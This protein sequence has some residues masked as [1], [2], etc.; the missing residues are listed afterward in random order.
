ML[1]GQGWPKPLLLE[2]RN[3]PRPEQL[4]EATSELLSRAAANI[5]RDLPVHHPRLADL[6]RLTAALMEHTE[7]PLVADVL[8]PIVRAHPS[9]LVRCTI[10]RHVTHAGGPSALFEPIAAMLDGE[11]AFAL[12]NHLYMP[13]ANAAMLVDPDTTFDRLGHHLWSDDGT[14][15][16]ETSRLKTAHVIRALSNKGGAPI[17]G[18][19]WS[20]VT[21]LLVH[22]DF[23][24]SSSVVQL[25]GRHRSDDRARASVREVLEVVVVQ[26]DPPPWH[27][28]L[29]AVGDLGL[30]EAVP[31][32]ISA[33]E[34]KLDGD[35]I[36]QEMIVL[37]RLG[38]PL[39]LGDL[40]AAKA[41]SKHGQHQR[42]LEGLIAQLEPAA[43]P[44]KVDDQAKR[45]PLV[46]PTA[47]RLRLE[48]STLDAS[49]IEQLL[50]L[51]RPQV[52]IHAKRSRTRPKLGES[53]LG[54]QPDLPSDATWPTALDPDRGEQVPLAFVG[55][56]RLEDLSVDAGVLPPEGMFWFF[57]REIELE[58]R[59]DPR[60]ELIEVACAV[61]YR[62][63]A[64]DLR[65]TSPP[66][67]LPFDLRSKPRALRFHGSMGLPPTNAE[68]TLDPLGMTMAE[69]RTYGQVLEPMAAAQAQ[70]LGYAQCAYYCGLPAVGHVLLLQIAE[71][72]VDLPFLRG[73]FVMIKE[74]D[75]RR[76]RFGEAYCVVDEC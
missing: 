40:R 49:R 53:R 29:K 43:K 66:E 73:M 70:V 46:G 15:P 2:I 48:S 50:R 31:H 26:R 5:E 36:E 45:I 69:R 72:S 18:R 60:G 3:F 42:R 33:L 19:W 62:Q 11:P 47:D 64:T 55:Q 65:S 67:T 32:V 58:T 20:A 21:P 23:Q 25:L 37:E 63:T 24:V 13:A 51:A 71:G 61:I 17:D 30:T 12:T 35:D 38:D 27:V 7:S 6:E 44:A 59:A 54:G 9:V 39:C 52:L 41:R 22:P 57:V 68:A 74:E 56:L 4:V 76:R 16:L 14:L 75:L 1:N 8:L 34:R 10:G 28:L